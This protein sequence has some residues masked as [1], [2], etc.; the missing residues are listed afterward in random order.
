MICAECLLGV[1]EVHAGL[2]IGVQLVVDAG[3][4]VA[5]GTRDDD[6]G[7]GV[8][9]IEDGHARDWRAT[10]AR[11]DDAGIV[12]CGDELDCCATPSRRLRPARRR[13]P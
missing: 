7:L 12:E 11:G 6:D 3:V 4:A 1:S 9:H 10:L 13:W 8:I 5:H 2:G